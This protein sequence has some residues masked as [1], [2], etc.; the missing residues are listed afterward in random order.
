VLPDEDL[1]IAA[2]SHHVTVAPVLV[3]LPLPLNPRLTH[4]STPRGVRA[5]ALGLTTTVHEAWLQAAESDEALPKPSLAAVRAALRRAR[6][7]ELLLGPP[8]AAMGD[9]LDELATVLRLMRDRIPVGGP[10]VARLVLSG[11]GREPAACESPDRRLRVRVQA[12]PLPSG[13]TSLHVS[14]LLRDGACE[15]VCVPASC[16]HA[17]ESGDVFGEAVVRFSDVGWE[18]VSIDLPASSATEPIRTH[19]VLEVGPPYRHDG[20]S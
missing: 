6:V 10:S 20:P 16:R 18:V 9:V 8:Q 19:V 12:N 5:L 17:D 13:G 3:E 11:L 4:V 7:S 2:P 14:V 1:E 15:G